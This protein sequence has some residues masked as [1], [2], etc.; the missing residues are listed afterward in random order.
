MIALYI[1]AA[2]L[3][4]ILLL[5]FSSLTLTLSYDKGFCAELSF[6]F[7]KAPLTDRKKPKHEK[8]EETKE[9]GNVEE[10]PLIKRFKDN[11]VTEN[12]RDGALLLRQV[13]PEI[14]TLLSR[15]RVRAL[16]LSVR[17]AD[18]D[19]A[20]TAIEYGAVCTAVY[21]LIAWLDEFMDLSVKKVDIVSAFGEQSP[22]ATLYLKLKARVIVLL[23]AAF[24]L[25][26]IY[27]N[28]TE[29]SKNERQEHSVDN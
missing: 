24:K 10:N 2:V 28:F 14:K 26:M 3:A 4:L 22:S 5:L 19:A 11:T 27:K 15:V 16:T 1:L 13:L 25:F 23:C 18:F 21:N 12:V 6:L 8:K 9:K 17:V 29:D 20:K 7:I